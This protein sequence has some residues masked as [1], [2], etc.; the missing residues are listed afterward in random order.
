MQAERANIKRLNVLGGNISRRFVINGSRTILK[1][2][3]F[4][5]SIILNRSSVN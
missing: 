4:T 3:Y 2:R 1:Y 5:H